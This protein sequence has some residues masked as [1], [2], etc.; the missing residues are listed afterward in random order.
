M[1]ERARRERQERLVARHPEAR[2]QAAQR[3]VEAE[4]AIADARRGSSATWTVG[5]PIVVRGQHGRELARLAHDHVRAPAARDLDHPR[6]RGARRT[7]RR[8]PPGRRSA[9]APRAASAHRPA[10]QAAAMIAS[11]G[12]SSGA[13]GSPERR[14]WCSTDGAA[15]TRTSCPAATQA[16][17][18][19]TSGPRCPAPRVVAKRMRIPLPGRRPRAAAIPAPQYRR[20]C[21]READDRAAEEDEQDH[22]PAASSRPWS[23]R[24]R[25]RRTTSRSGCRRR[26]RCP[27]ASCRGR[28][29][30]CAQPAANG[31]TGSRQLGHRL[32]SGIAHRIARRPA[33]RNR[34]I[35]RISESGERL[36][37][38]APAGGGAVHPARARRA[39]RRRAGRQRAR[40]ARA[41]DEPSAGDL[42][43]AA[44][45]ARAGA[46][47]AR[48]RPGASSRA[49]RATSTP[50]PASARWR[51]RTPIPRRATRRCATT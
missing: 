49:P 13:N 23:A 8:R 30:R 48:A 15:A 29:R 31:L 2:P 41:R 39:A 19:G 50:R 38:S 42:R 22:D 45:R 10:S 14:T 18:K 44:A 17:A 36:G 20:A 32:R 3:L 9:P 51:G 12:S 40:A 37:L 46:R 34:T 1:L 4:L 33:I 25:A 7:R 5:T 43:A 16:W 26:A 28:R 24:S 6:Q 27:S 35:V 21:T 47:A 11:S